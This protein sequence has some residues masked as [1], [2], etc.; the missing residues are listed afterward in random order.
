MVASNKLSA[1]FSPS[2]LAHIKSLTKAS[3]RTNSNESALEIHSKW[4]AKRNDPVWQRY[5]RWLVSNLNAGKAKAAVKRQ[6]KVGCRPCASNK[7]YVRA[8]T[9]SGRRKCMKNPAHIAK[10]NAGQMSYSKTCIGKNYQLEKQGLIVWK[11][12]KVGNPSPLQAAIRSKLHEA[13]S[14]GA[15]GNGALIAL[16]QKHFEKNPKAGAM[17]AN[18]RAFKDFVASKRSNE[19]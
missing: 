10:A 2:E 18:R 12:R 15:G 13:R 8:T 3:K 17:V 14:V 16:Q 6:S 1:L 4:S 9:K 11:P 19:K 5:S 7:F